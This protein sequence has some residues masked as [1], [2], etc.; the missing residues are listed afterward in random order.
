MS[1]KRSLGGTPV[2]AL[3]RGIAATDF[4]QVTA[5][6][7]GYLHEDFQHVHGSVNAALEA[8]LR[9]SG[10][11]DRAALAIEAVRLRRVLDGV[12]L[13]ALRTL[14]NVVFRSAWRPAT[15]HEVM[16]L[17]DRMRAAA[18]TPPSIDPSGS[19]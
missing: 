4:P 6:C 18:A 8:F 7:R 14:Y 5:F 13:A 3:P 9:E 11:E 12:P 19:A 16:A 10:E 2:R 17:V 15:R 1:A